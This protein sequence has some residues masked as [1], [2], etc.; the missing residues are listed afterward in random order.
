MSSLLRLSL[1]SS[2]PLPF[3]CSID[4]LSTRKGE[5]WGRPTNIRSSECPRFISA[6]GSLTCKAIFLFHCTLTRIKVW[7][8]INL[9]IW[10]GSEKLRDTCGILIVACECCLCELCDCCLLFVR[11]CCCFYLCIVFG[12]FCFIFIKSW[13]DRNSLTSAIMPSSIYLTNNK[14]NACYFKT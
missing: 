7:D 9:Y 13:T 2:L 4:T 8:C 1:A 5:V 11:E 6:V 3:S 12:W 14:Q 10:Y